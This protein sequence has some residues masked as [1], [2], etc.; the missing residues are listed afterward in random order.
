MKLLKVLFF[1]K[2]LMFTC[3]AQNPYDFVGKQHNLLLQNLVTCNNSEDYKC[4]NNVITYTFQNKTT[5]GDL[6]V[7][8]FLGLCNLPIHEKQTIE[9]FL[10]ISDGLCIDEIEYFLDSL[11]NEAI[12]KK[13]SSITLGF[14]S[15]AKHSLKFW[16]SYKWGDE[17]KKPPFLAIV[18]ADAVGLIKGVVL[19]AIF[20]VG[21]NFIFGVPDSIGIIGGSTIAIGFTALDSFRFSKKY[22]ERIEF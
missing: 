8:T 5:Y 15:I 18:K 12:K 13:S 3:Y 22:K 20:W 10:R 9:D 19:G 4:L 6:D 2:I 7:Y 14:W 16:R 11:E 17:D 1:I 21:S